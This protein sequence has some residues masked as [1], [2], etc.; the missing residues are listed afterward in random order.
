MAAAKKVFVALFSLFVTIDSAGNILSQSPT[1]V[2]PETIDTKGTGTRCF[3]FTVGGF[4]GG[5]LG[6]STARNYAFMRKEEMQKGYTQKLGQLPPA[7]GLTKA[8]IEVRVLEA[9]MAQAK[10]TG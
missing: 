10:A 1:E 4:E 2:D 3:R 8:K 5:A 9:H 6:C 7:Q